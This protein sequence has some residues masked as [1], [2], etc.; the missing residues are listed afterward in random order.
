MRF[1]LS[2]RAPAL[3]VGLVASHGLTDLRDLENVM[4]YALA[5]LPIPGLLVTL[6]FLVA[7]FVHFA[8]D[9]GGEAGLQ[10]HV[11]WLIVG[12]SA[13]QDAAADVALVYMLLFHL[14]AH[15]SRV[16]AEGTWAARGAVVGAVAAG[17][18]LGACVP[19]GGLTLT[20]LHQKLVVAH[21]LADDNF[22]W[23]QSR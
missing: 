19:A 21:V 15:H 4:P 10:L 5:L 11:A 3:A 7:S 20:H 17:V 9:I 1:E 12:L 13:G 23:A 2:P 16:W 6:A 22:S 14:P 8:R 18:G